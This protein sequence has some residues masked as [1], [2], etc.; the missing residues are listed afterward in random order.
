MPYPQSA[1]KAVDEANVAQN[2][3]EVD[4]EYYIYI[5]PSEKVTTYHDAASEQ[6]TTTHTYT[7][8]LTEKIGR[9]ES[10][11]SENAHIFY[12]IWLIGM[13]A[14][15]GFFLL[16]NLFFRIRIYSDRVEVEEDLLLK[17]NLLSYPV[18]KGQR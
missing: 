2:R 10:W 12:G 3:E 1:V 6:K 7:Y 4:T 16:A 14:V 5:M 9:L 17:R 13:A 8:V 11:F 15:S 18:K